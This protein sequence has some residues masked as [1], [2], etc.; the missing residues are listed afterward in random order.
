METIIVTDSCCDL[1]YEYIK[2]NHIEMLP[3][4]I[5]IDNT[6]KKDDLAITGAYSAFYQ[7]ILEGALPKTSQVNSYEFKEVFEKY[8]TKESNEEISTLHRFFF[9]T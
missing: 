2:Q 1:P 7:S 5:T 4:T 3:M 9:C 6:D 8:F